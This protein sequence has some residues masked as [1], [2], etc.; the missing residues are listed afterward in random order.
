MKMTKP[1]STDRWTGL[2]VVLFAALFLSPLI[3]LPPSTLFGE[4]T[5]FF[6]YPYAVIK[7]L[8]LQRHE[9]PLWDPCSGSGDPIL[10]NPLAGQFYPPMWLVFF[11]PTVLSGLRWIIYLHLIA[12]SLGGYVLARWLGCRPIA[13][14]LVPIGLLF[15][16]YTSTMLI[17]GLPGVLYA[18]TW[19]TWG[20]ALLWRGITESRRGFLIGAGACLAAQILSGT[21]YEVHFTFLLYGFLIFFI[22]LT[23]PAPWD[24]RLRQIVFQGSILLVSVFCLSAVKLL[25]ILEYSA[26]STRSFSLYEIES[27]GQNPTLKEMGDFFI[28]YFGTP[29]LPEIQWIN[30]SF[31]GM[32]FLLAILFRRQP[33]PLKRPAMLF[34]GILLLSCWAAL[35]PAAAPLDLYAVLYHWVPGFQYSPYTGRILS[36]A[37]LVLPLLAALGMS[38]F[39]DYAST[40]SRWVSRFSKIGIILFIVGCFSFVG[41]PLNRYLLQY[42]YGHLERVPTGF[43]AAP[44]SP[45]EISTEG[46]SRTLEIGIKLKNIS[47]EVWQKQRPLEYL[48]DDEVIGVVRIPNETAPNQIVELRS[49]YDFSK[50]AGN[51]PHRLY[52]R[53]EES[54]VLIAT[55]EWAGD[56]LSVRTSEVTSDDILSGSA[57]LGRLPDDWNALLGAIAR[58]RTPDMFRVY[59]AAYG[60]VYPY[61]AFLHGFQMVTYSNHGFMPKYHLFDHYSNNPAQL[62]RLL[63]MFKILNVRYLIA[64]KDFNYLDHTE[65]QLIK[66]QS[67]AKLY[68]LKSAFPRVWI[69][70][71]AAL[72]IGDDLDRDFNSLEAKLIVYHDDFKPNEWAVFTRRTEF[73]DHLKIADLLPFPVLFLTRPAI[74][75][76][77]AAKKLLEDYQAAGGR[78]LYIPYSE[79]RYTDQ[80]L[81]SNSML[82]NELA[83]KTLGEDAAVKLKEL[84]LEPLPTSSSP[85]QLRIEES[86]PT[87]WRLRVHTEQS[88]TPVVVSET[89]FPGWEASVD[90]RP[91]PL[92]MADGVIRG[93]MVTGSGNHI[94]ELHYRPSSFYWGGLITLGFIGILLLRWIGKLSKDKRTA[95]K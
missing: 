8:V 70:K 31:L 73:I 50:D 67:D 43:L 91:V 85:E 13:A 82:D 95:I 59:S 80:H 5:S 30:W 32:V 79:Y 29:R 48:L 81:I 26:I 53:E 11:T 92:Y 74:E 83:A 44:V 64:A 16:P 9:W 4:G 22:G 54:R 55:V 20:T 41:L 14:V 10:G 45:S 21:T 88:A 12:A 61:T 60:G 38:A 52:L 63:K 23:T 37:R 7:Q 19:L 24:K 69:P 25:P 51:G 6:G 28:N 56:R 49:R 66:T 87:Y 3:L 33:S 78:I 75:S 57:V 34:A 76:P 18:I 46:K 1:I 65:A 17:N 27:L 84:F 86:Q 72:L 47:D 89:Y 2:A 58:W 71:K 94:I 93:I 62:A 15:A 36:L 35:G 90:G 42:P 39:L 77:P 40:R 68:E